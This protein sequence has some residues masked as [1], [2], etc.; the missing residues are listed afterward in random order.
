MQNPQNSGPSTGQKVPSA[1]PFLQDSSLVTQAPSE[2]SQ[3]IIPSSD[4]KAEQ[5]LLSPPKP[6]LAQLD[7][8]GGI[9]INITIP[10]TCMVCRLALAVRKSLSSWVLRY[11]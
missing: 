3:L 11:D 10:V 7:S 2:S 4:L 1:L 5:K 9:R 8:R 6:S